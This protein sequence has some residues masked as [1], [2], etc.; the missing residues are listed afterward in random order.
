M[1]DYDEEMDHDSPYWEDWDA[2]EE[3]E[4]PQ[5]PDDWYDL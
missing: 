4:E 1:M 3:I 2:D 5:D